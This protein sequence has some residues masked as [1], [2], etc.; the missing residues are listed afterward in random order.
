MERAVIGNASHRGLIRMVETMVE[1]KVSLAALTLEQAE[2]LIRKS[3]S[4]TMTQEVLKKH[5]HMGAP[6]NADGT[7]NI[8]HYVAWLI[9]ENEKW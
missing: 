9:K 2:K 6:T 3:G 5:I 4:S 7:I 8:L 1:T